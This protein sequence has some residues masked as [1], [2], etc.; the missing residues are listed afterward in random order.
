MNNLKWFVA[1]CYCFSFSFLFFGPFYKTISLDEAD[2]N[3]QSSEADSHL[4][5]PPWMVCGES[6]ILRQSNY[7]GIIAFIGATEF[8]TGL[9]IGVE[10]DAPLGTIIALYTMTLWLSNNWKSAPIL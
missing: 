4:D 6:V 10:L 9:W 8:A 2:S 1:V 5:L 7:S 3:V